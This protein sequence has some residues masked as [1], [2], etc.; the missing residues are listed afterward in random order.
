MAL[1]TNPSAL[2]LNSIHLKC[3]HEAL[4]IYL[5]DLE[6]TPI[7]LGGATGWAAGPTP[8]SRWQQAFPASAFM[9]NLNSSERKLRAYQ[10]S[11]Q[12]TS[13]H[14][15]RATCRLICGALDG[16]DRVACEVQIL[17]GN[18]IA[19]MYHSYEDWASVASTSNSL[20]SDVFDSVPFRH[21]LASRC[22][23]PSCLRSV[24]SS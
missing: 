23:T 1:L 16:H 4:S 11:T 21:K 15:R 13:S 9:N 10:R 14:S 3:S 5:S 22:R 24:A 8:R 2:A 20:T 19:H 17:C 6:L 12:L 18:I 7:A